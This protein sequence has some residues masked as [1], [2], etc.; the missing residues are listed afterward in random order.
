MLEV[1]AGCGVSGLIAARF[2]AKVR[3]Y[4][5]AH[6]RSQLLELS[7]GLTRG[8]NVGTGGA[9]RQ[10][11]RSG[12]YVEPEHRAE[13]SPRYRRTRDHTV[14]TINRTHGVSVADKAE[15][16]VMKWVDDLPALKEKYPPFETI[17]GT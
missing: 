8:R 9:H 11:R 3:P 2:A 13:L 16:M 14:E 17:I 1:G 5:R 7:L 12:G 10:E 15:G 4:P 6:G